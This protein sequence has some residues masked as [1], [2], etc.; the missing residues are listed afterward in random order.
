MGGDIA[1]GEDEEKKLWLKVEETTVVQVGR[2]GL[3]VLVHYRD[4]E[5][6]VMDKD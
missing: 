2:A 3:P 5:I 4:K 6:P 1:A